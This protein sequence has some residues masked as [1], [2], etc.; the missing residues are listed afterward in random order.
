M[1][2]TEG[3]ALYRMFWAIVGFPVLITSN[4]VI[5]YLAWQVLEQ[6]K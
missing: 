3:L 6:D 2:I 1:E 4:V 5:A